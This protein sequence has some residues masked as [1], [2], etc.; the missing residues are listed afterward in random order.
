MPGVSG[1][2]VLYNNGAL[3]SMRFEPDIWMADATDEQVGAVAAKV[4]ELRGGTFDDHD[5]YVDLFVAPGVT[6]IGSAR[7]GPLRQYPRWP[8][9][10]A[11]RF[12]PESGD[13]L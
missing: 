5:Q 8:A 10:A 11:H 1:V 13:C 3:G 9:H 12:R 4:D 2:K 7:P 6:I